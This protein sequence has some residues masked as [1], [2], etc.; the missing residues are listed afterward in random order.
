MSHWNY[1]VVKRTVKDGV[2]F[3]IHECY[4]NDR[5]RPDGITTDSVEPRGETLAE[6]KKDIKM[7]LQALKR[8]VL[9]YEDL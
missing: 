2:I 5:G 1:R 6:L 4:Y 7:Y 3:A 9:R 8:P